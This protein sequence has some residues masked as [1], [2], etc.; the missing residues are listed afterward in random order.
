MALAVCF[1]VVLGGSLPELGNAAR[2][3]IFN[4]TEGIDP[5]YFN[6]LFI[7]LGILGIIVCSLA[8][9]RRLLQSSTSGMV[10]K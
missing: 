8:L 4:D 10:K 7:A 1:G 9:Y 2:Y 5:H 6:G 3:Y